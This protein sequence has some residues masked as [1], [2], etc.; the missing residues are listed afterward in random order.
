MLHHL[1]INAGWRSGKENRKFLTAN[2]GTLY[3]FKQLLFSRYQYH[4]G[5]DVCEVEDLEHFCWFSEDI[6]DVKIESSSNY[7][8]AKTMFTTQAAMLLWVQGVGEWTI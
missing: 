7:S 8:E 6:E 5:R 2:V 4:S 1:G 3:A